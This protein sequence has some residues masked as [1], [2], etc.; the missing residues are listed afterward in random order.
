MEFSTTQPKIAA[1]VH[2]PVLKKSAFVA[3]L[4]IFGVFNTLAGIISLVSAIILFSDA[5]MPSLASAM[6]TDAA[7]K[8]SLGALII[9]S[10]RAFTKGKFLSIWLYAGSILLDSLYNLITGYPLNYI[11]IGFGLLLIWQTLKFRNELELK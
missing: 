4:A 3:A 6:L 11:F 10:S 1:I 7:Y 8:L 2:Q 9:A 5:S